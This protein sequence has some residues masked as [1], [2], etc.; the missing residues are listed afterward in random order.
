MPAKKKRAPTPEV[1]KRKRAAEAT[2]RAREREAER[3]RKARS[4]AAKRGWEARRAAAAAEE[5]KREA[6]RQ[7]DRARR[8]AAKAAEVAEEAKREAR[9]AKDRARRAAKRHADEAKGLKRRGRRKHEP[10][11]TEGALSWELADLF[12]RPPLGGTG[13]VYRYRDGTVETELRFPAWFE[14]QHEREWAEIEMHV[15]DLLMRL[16]PGGWASVGVY[17][18]A[19]SGERRER[20]DR[21]GSQNSQVWFYPRKIKDLPY[22][23][24]DVRQPAS[25]KKGEALMNNL[26]RAGY[27]VMG[28]G[29]RTSNAPTRPEHWR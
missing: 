22:L 27:V 17:F 4:S 15:R 16:G 13:Q 9:R 20:Y 28:F 10:A 26:K 23:F 21:E 7:R 1:S 18:R 11:L 24:L 12:A 25:G 2:R 3:L 8:A 14:G 6:R 29:V 5:A 19:P